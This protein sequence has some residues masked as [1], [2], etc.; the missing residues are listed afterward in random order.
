M[1]GGVRVLFKTHVKAKVNA[2]RFETWFDA[3]Q[4]ESAPLW[5]VVEGFFECGSLIHVCQF[6]SA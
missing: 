1:N 6:K 4:D 2:K 5:V 3:A